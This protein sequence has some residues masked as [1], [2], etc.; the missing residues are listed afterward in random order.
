MQKGLCSDN[1]P[2]LS[3]NITTTF[4]PFPNFLATLNAAHIAAP[5]DIPQRSPSL[6]DNCLA[7]SAASESVT[8]I[9]SLYIFVFNTPGKNPAPIPAILWGPGFPPERTGD[10]AGSTAA[11]HISF[12]YF[13]TSRQ[14]LLLSRLCRRLRQSRQAQRRARQVSQQ[15]LSLC[16]SP[17]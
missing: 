12:F 1:A 7:V 3:G 5:D 9:T 13:L 6:S 11:I 16:V 4:F 8:G 14:P 15:L 2:P 17:D 10:A